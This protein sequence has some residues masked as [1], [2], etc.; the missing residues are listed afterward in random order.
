M[1]DHPSQL[2]AV[3]DMSEDM[4]AHTTITSPSPPLMK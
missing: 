2:A 4:P 3:F 1:P